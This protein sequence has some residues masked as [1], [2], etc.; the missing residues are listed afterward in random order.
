MNDGKVFVDTNVI[1]YAYDISAG[2][3]HHKAMGTMKDLWSEGHGIISTQVLQE[4]FVSVTRKITKPLDVAS[5]KAIVKDLSKWKTVTIDGEIILDAIDI[6]AE[7]RYSFWDSVIIASALSGGAGTLL[8]E[9]LSDKHKI[10]GIVLENP[11][12]R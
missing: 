2:E 12:A 7:H 11:F 3:K 1:V 5:A 9:D 10:K 6:H 8:S 4:F